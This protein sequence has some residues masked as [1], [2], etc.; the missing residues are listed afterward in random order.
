MKFANIE[1]RIANDGTLLPFSLDFNDIYFQMGNGTF[2]TDYV[3]IDGNQLK[4]RFLALR[5][6]YFCVFE[7]GFGTGLNFFAV[8]ETWLKIAPKNAKLRFISVEKTP[9]HLNDLQKV[10]E[11]T[12]IKNLSSESCA[13][14]KTG[15]WR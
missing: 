8:A 14:H 1:W 15:G 7:T 3:F 10:A 11:I 4:S 2:E 6:T 5:K 13:D 9:L 12:H